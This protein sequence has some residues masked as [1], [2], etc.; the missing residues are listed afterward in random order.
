VGDPEDKRQVPSCGI[1]AN[2]IEQDGVVWLRIKTTVRLFRRRLWII[3]F[4]KMRRIERGDNFRNI[5]SSVENITFYMQLFAILTGWYVLMYLWHINIC[6][7][8]LEKLCITY[9]INSTVS[10]IQWTIQNVHITKTN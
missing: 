5:F 3:V 1:N 6:C 9:I 10:E 2:I 8:Q 4:H 7:R